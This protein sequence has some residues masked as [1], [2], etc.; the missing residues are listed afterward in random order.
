MVS[1]ILQS[2]N[3]AKQEA[4]DGH[5]VF[6]Y[7]MSKQSVLNLSQNSDNFFFWLYW[8]ASRPQMILAPS[9]ETASNLTLWT[10]C[11]RSTVGVSLHNILFRLLHSKHNHDCCLRCRYLDLTTQ[12]TN[13]FTFPASGKPLLAVP[14]LRWQLRW[15]Q[16]VLIKESVS[17]FLKTCF[18]SCPHSKFPIWHNDQEELITPPF[19]QFHCAKNKINYHPTYILIQNNFS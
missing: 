8:W 9:T 1:I 16:I 5:G 14:E 2:N 11:Y 12:R 7:W 17:F 4:D 6:L 13:Y 19:K 3:S 15:V 18:P 10:Q